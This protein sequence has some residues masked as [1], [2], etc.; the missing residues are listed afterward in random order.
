MAWVAAAES[1][2]LEEQSSKLHLQTWTRRW[3]RD[4]D[5]W[6]ERLQIK[7]P[8]PSL[9]RVVRQVLMLQCAGRLE[10]SQ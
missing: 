7:T 9:P 6:E 3:R 1:L 5:R 8:Q 4:R 2:D 10:T